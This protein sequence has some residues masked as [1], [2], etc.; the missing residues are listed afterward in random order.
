MSGSSGPG[1]LRAIVRY[2]VLLLILAVAV[3]LLLPLEELIPGRLP[4]ARGP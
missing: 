4:F 2:A 3:V 1:R